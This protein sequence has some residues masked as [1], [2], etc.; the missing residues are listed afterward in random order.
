M[1]SVEWKWSEKNYDVY[2]RFFVALTNLNI[3][4]NHLREEALDRYYR[5]CTRTYKIDV[6]ND[7]KR[8]LT[9]K[10]YHERRRART[11][12]HLSLVTH[13]VALAIYGL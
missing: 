3:H 1:I 6:F 11:D 12:V 9:Q 2:V 10:F 8:R 13:S 4:W 5:I 7:R